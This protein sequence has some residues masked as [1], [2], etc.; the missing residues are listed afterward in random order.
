MVQA[1]LLTDLESAQGGSLSAYTP[2]RHY[3]SENGLRQHH[4]ASALLAESPTRGLILHV[5]QRGVID[6]PVSASN[7]HR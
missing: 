4:V 2:A 3:G 7:F 6:E 1:E 5:M